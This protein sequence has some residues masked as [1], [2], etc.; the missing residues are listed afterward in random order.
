MNTWNSGRARK[1]H[2]GA[3]CYTDDMKTTLFMF[4]SLDGKIST[5][6]N[7]DRDFDK[8]LSNIGGAKDGLQQY[9]K[10]E[11]K[12]DWYSFN[13]GRCMEKVGWNDNKASIKQLPVVFVI[14]DNKPHLTARGVENLIRRTEKLYII[15]T[16]NDHP[17]SKISNEQLEVIN[18]E[19]TID[20]TELFD[21]L[22]EKGVKAMT[23]QSGGDMNATL[24]R[25]GLINELSVVIAPILVGGKDT[26]SIIGGE[27]IKSVEDLQKI[28]SLELVNIE[29]LEHNYIHVHYKISN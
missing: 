12:T 13:T 10:L 19:Q 21:R 7:D 16:N 23:I 29:R 6:S 11:E 8:D 4:M 24:L 22:S 2:W 26:Q 25:D 1:A 5:G 20:F 27:S 28:K 14:V 9:Y 17:A 18:Y 3:F 15:T